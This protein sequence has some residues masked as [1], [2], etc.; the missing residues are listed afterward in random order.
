MSTTRKQEPLGCS[1]VRAF[2]MGC[3]LAPSASTGMPPVHQLNRLSPWIK[4]QDSWVWWLS[5]NLS[6]LEMEAEGSPVPNQTVSKE[7]IWEHFS[8]FACKAQSLSRSMPCN[9]RNSQNFVVVCQGAGG[10]NWRVGVA[11]A[12]SIAQAGLELSIYP[13]LALNS[14]DTSCLSL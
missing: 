12:Y 4:S 3:A 9:P 2:A 14:H 5:Y 10:G 7:D 8:K 11:A 6:T 1:Q 13:R